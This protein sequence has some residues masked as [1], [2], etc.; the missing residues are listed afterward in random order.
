MVRS[1]CLPLSYTM[2]AT[3]GSPVARAA[4]IAN[5]A[6]S[7]SVIVSTTIASAPPAARA[8][9]C[10]SKLARREAS[11]TCPLIS[12]LPLGPIEAKTRARVPAARFEISTPARFTWSSFETSACPASAIR[13][14]AKG[15]GEN[16]V[17]P[18]LHVGP[19]D[20]LDAIG[21]LEVPEVGHFARARVRGPGARCPRLRRAARGPRRSARRSAS[22][23][24]S[25]S[26]ELVARRE[27]PRWRCPRRRRP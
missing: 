6:S 21:V 17:A 4:S 1:F 7:R 10:C 14:R 22:S 20:L 19:G 5:R 2:Q 3:T 12:S 18:G 24:T 23:Q 26:H 8:R 27:P 15:V 16:D 25:G 9:A 13:V 11:S